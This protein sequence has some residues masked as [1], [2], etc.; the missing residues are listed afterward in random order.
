TQANV[1]LLVGRGV[2][3]VGPEEGDLAEGETGIGR[4]AEP[5]EI[6]ARVRQL[7]EGGTLKGKRVLVTAGGTREPIDAVRFVGNRASG[8]MGVALAEEA[9]RRGARVTL[10]GANL[11]VAHPAGVE[12]VETP[13]A[14]DL[15]REA[16]A[17]GADAD[18]VV[19][20][21]AVA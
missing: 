20:A 21:A 17:R 6:A 5:E 11:A 1:A 9:A 15:E 16:L 18:V 8:R 2:E 3:L 12:V 7:L 13:S 14:A 19:M 10:L 4:M